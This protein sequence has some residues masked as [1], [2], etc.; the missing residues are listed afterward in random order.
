MPLHDMTSKEMAI[1]MRPASKKKEKS[2]TVSCHGD[3]F[4]TLRF[5][6]RQTIPLKSQQFSKSFSHDRNTLMCV[7]CMCMCGRSDPWWED[8][9]DSL[10]I[11]GMTKQERLHWNITNNRLQTLRDRC[12][13]KWLSPKRTVFHVWV[14]LLQFSHLTGP[15]P[16]MSS[17]ENPSSKSPL[18]STNQNSYSYYFL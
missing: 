17:Q 6:A 1:P 15:L 16:C 4:A 14:D 11:H 3:R 10:C 2:H 7:Y 8:I 13:C 9:L 12:C 5:S 18:S